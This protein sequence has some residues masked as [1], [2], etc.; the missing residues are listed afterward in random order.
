MRNFKKNIIKYIGKKEFDNLIPLKNVFQFLQGIFF[1]PFE[2]SID[3]WLHFLKIIVPPELPTSVRAPYINFVDNYLIRKFLSINARYPPHLWNYYKY[4]CIN[5]TT[6]AA[7]TINKKLKTLCGAGFLPYSASCV[8]T[9]TFKCNYIDDYQWK[10]K[11]DNLNKKKPKTIKRQKDIQEI[12]DDFDRLDFLSQN[13]AEN[14]INYTYKLGHANK[15]KEIVQVE[16][17]LSENFE[18][19]EPVLLSL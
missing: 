14:V 8:K 4:G 16:Q 19:S 15:D 9:H 11:R 12:I 7:E 10:V 2:I 5:T 6:N 3:H 18:N 1:L 17:P 13:N